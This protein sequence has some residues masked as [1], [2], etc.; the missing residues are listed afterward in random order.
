M[1][2]KRVLSYCNVLLFLG[3]AGVASAVD[4]SVDEAAIKGL[5]S[6]VGAA[7]EPNLGQTD[8]SVDF[9][10]RGHGYAVFLRPNGAVLSLTG[11][12]DAYS[13]IAVE[14]VGGSPSAAPE[15]GALLPGT[16][17]YMLG[18]DRNQWV[19]GV[20]RHDSITYR[21]VYPGVDTVY[22]SQEGRLEYDLCVQPGADPGQIRI[23]FNGADTVRIDDAGLLTVL[24]N[25]GEVY[26]HMPEI[27]Q[28]VDGARRAVCGHYVPLGDHEVGFELGAYDPTLPLII[29]PVLYYS[30][31]LGGSAVDSARAV[32]IITDAGTPQTHFAIVVGS[33][34]STDFPSIPSTT[35]PGGTDAY[36]MLFKLEETSANCLTYSAY[37]GGPS[38]DVATCV[39][40]ASSTDLLV[41]IGGVT[42]STSGFIGQLNNA[43]IQQSPVRTDGFIAVFRHPGTRTRWSSIRT[44]RATSA[45]LRTTAS[46]AF[47][48][49]LLPKSPPSW[50]TPSPPTSRS[51]RPP[52]TSRPT[53]ARA[54]KTVFSRRWAK[55]PR[56]PRT[57]HSWASTMVR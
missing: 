46:M 32:Q 17:D 43:S 51:R 33:T 48:T 12:A 34:A 27:Y 41:A 14:F 52:R 36:V 16:A 7:F 39:A 21:N 19:K 24:V 29:D 38:T 28:V 15:A 55:A 10:A 56:P 25:G 18:S 6:T 50:G 20:P 1:G 2:L 42:N 47:F 57:P 35:R 53:P 44:I 23:R 54:D 5:T 37:I 45:A 11:A 13:A 31:Y 4:G 49:R 9:L 30:S 8:P 22:Y 3:L 40:T 26:Q